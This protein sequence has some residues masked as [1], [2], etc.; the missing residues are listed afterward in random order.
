MSFHV[1]VTQTRE[2]QTVWS[3]TTGVE[4]EVGPGMF[5]RFEKSKSGNL[6]VTVGDDNTRKEEEITLTPEEAE[7]FILAMARL[8]PA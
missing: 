7:A 5:V 2:P 1:H 6:N 3:K 8:V 4:I